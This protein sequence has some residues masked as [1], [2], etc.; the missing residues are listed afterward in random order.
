QSCPVL[1]A[2]AVARQRD[3]QRNPLLSHC[4][5]RPPELPAQLFVVQRAEQ[6][7]LLRAPAVGGRI[8]DAQLFPLLPDRVLRPAALLR[9]FLVGQ[10]A[11]QGQLLRG[12]ARLRPTVRDVER[13]RLPP[14]GHTAADTFPRLRLP[15]PAGGQLGIQSLP[16]LLRALVE[17]LDA[18]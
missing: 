2:P 14:R 4:G 10:R 5:P 13:A 9:Q 1:L 18:E 11:R 16:Q 7:N 15:L 3:A 12:P 6:R 17:L 8:S